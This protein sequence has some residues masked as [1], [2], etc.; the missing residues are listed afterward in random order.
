MHVAV[1]PTAGVTRKV[2]RAPC[3][4][5]YLECSDNVTAITLNDLMR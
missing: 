3:D 4:P 5:G 1:C 2:V